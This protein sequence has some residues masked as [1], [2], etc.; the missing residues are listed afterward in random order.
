MTRPIS[1]QALETLYKKAEFIK[2]QKE[3]QVQNKR[4]KLG[5]KYENK[6]SIKNTPKLLLA[7]LVMK[8]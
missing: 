5:L 8:N 6:A 4:I 3:E 7:I 1:N 2:K